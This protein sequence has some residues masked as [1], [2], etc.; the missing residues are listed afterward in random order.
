[1]QTRQIV[2]IPDN[3]KV[4]YCKKKNIIIFKG[5]IGQKSLKIDDLLTISCINQELNLLDAVSNKFSNH[6]KK[7]LRSLRGSTVSV[8]KQLLIEITTPVFQKLNL[9]GVGYRAFPVEHFE[10]HLLML[11]LGYSHPIYFKIPSKTSVFCLKLTKLFVYGNSYQQITF[12]AARIRSNKVPE[13]YKG[14]GI[15]YENEKILLKEGKKI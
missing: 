9:V 14:K 12:T 11:R 10:N 7:K 15:V 3:I 5:P 8:L 4:F 6:E 2:K 1:M 13:P